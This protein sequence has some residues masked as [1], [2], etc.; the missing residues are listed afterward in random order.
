MIVITANGFTA[1]ATEFV[2]EA[3]SIVIS[4]E[5]RLLE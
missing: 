3:V 5:Y 2:I 1:D 4:F